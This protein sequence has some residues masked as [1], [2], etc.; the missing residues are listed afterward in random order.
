MTGY[1]S[2]SITNDMT[3]REQQT[4]LYYQME[5]DKQTARLFLLDS[6]NRDALWSYRIDAQSIY[7]KIKKDIMLAYGQLNII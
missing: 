5:E 7:L 6:Q 4:Q 2:E 1:L 3:T